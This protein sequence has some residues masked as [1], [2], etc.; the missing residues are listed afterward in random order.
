M[1]EAISAIH[2]LTADIE[3]DEAGRA[4]WRIRI[5]VN[6]QELGV[7]A[8]VVEAQLRGGDIAIYA[9]RYNLHQGVFSLDPRTV[10]EGEMALIVARL[11]EIADHAKINFYRNRVAINV[12]AKDIA[13]AREIFD[14]AEG[15]A[16]IGVL[17]AQFSSVDGGSRKLN[18]GWRKYRPFQ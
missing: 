3:Q 7:D 6:A 17:S 1:V 14:A 11:K 15:H 10:A 4:I 18:V 2:G 9:R 16:V 12:L 13:N 5:R 8:R